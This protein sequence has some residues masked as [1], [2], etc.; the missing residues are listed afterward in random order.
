VLLA[1]GGFDHNAEMRREFLGLDEDWSLGAATNEGDG[2]RVG[3]ELGAAVDLM[4]DAWWMP[5]MP[6]AADGSLIGLV[7]ERQYPGQFVVNGAGERFVNEASP[8]VVFGQA[9]LAGERTGTR[10]VPAWMIVDDVAWRRNIIAGHLP[11]TA[12]PKPWRERGCAHTAP[13]LARLAELIDVPSAA[14]EATAARYNALA[15]AGRDEDF[16]RGE[17]AYDRY[18]GDTSY[19]NP[20]LAPVVR[21]PFYAFAIVPGDLGTKGGL[22]TD[23]EA[24]VLR[25]DGSPIVGLYAAGNVAASVMGTRYAG[26][27][28]TLGTAMTWAYIAAK[29]VQTTKRPFDFPKPTG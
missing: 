15:A 3:R 6:S 29:H 9:Q 11:G 14:L 28:A 12:F 2:I 23:V 27:G 10:H 8:Y 16:Q 17:S 13:T 21:P 18:Y 24:R 19:P 25:E 4:E 5:T 1:S 7:A 20:N 22:L 26:P